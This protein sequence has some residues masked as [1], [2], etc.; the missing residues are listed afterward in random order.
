MA[1][2]IQLNT[3]TLSDQ[4]R[5][6]I[7]FD[8]LA[9]TFTRQAQQARTAR[10]RWESQILEYL[11]NTKMTNVIIQITG[12]RLTVHEEKHQ[13]PLTLQRLEQLLHEYFNKKMPGSDNET[14]MIMNYIKENR[15]SVIETKL[16][17]S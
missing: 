6:W 17:K 9:A 10:A 15:G 13:L 8:N 2:P 14:E 3:K 16:K 1:A 5:S 7:H 12:G 4:I 11:K